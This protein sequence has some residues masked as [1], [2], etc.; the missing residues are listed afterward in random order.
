MISSTSPN[1]FLSIGWPFSISS[2]ICAIK[3]S[4]SFSAT[5]T[6]SSIP[7]NDVSLPSFATLSLITAP[8]SKLY[9]LYGIN[10]ANRGLPNAIEP[11]DI[12]APSAITEPSFII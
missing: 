3:R 4:L 2:P 12:Q 10:A 1:V 5:R 9:P 8:S 11:F 7:C 6:S